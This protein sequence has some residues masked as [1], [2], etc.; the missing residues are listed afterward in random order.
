MLKKMIEE[1][2][3]YMVG[4]ITFIAVV[5]TIVLIVKIYQQDND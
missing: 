2:L 3:T 5:L 1:L 4:S